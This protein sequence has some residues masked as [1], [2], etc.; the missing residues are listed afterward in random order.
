MK[1]LSKYTET[2][3]LAA[4]CH[5]IDF[6]WI[7][8]TNFSAMSLLQLMSYHGEWVCVAEGPEVMYFWVVCVCA[9]ADWMY[10]VFMNGGGLSESDFQ[11][12]D[13]LVP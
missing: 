9:C 11:C 1:L 4:F 8:I 6:P 5:L 7:F 13:G 10:L 3:P 2:C 12:S